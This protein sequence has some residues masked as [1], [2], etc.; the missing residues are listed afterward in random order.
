MIGNV[1][2]WTADHYDEGYYSRSPAV[3]PRGPESGHFRVLRGGSWIRDAAMLRASDRYPL[4]P[5]SPDHAIG[6]R[7]VLDEMP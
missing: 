3:D 4:L 1:W 6:F 2:E 7:C 5:D